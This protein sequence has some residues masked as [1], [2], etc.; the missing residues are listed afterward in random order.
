MV[1]TVLEE[2]PRVP[3]SDRRERLLIASTRVLRVRASASRNNPLIL[4]KATSMGL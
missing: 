3:G 2:A 1:A 4:E